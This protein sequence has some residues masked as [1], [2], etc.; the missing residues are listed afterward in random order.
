MRL[1]PLLPH[2][3]SLKYAGINEI[4]GFS[5]YH[6]DHNSKNRNSYYP[7]IGVSITVNIE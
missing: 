6:Y 3:P 2:L 5:T 1:L 7:F 4:Y